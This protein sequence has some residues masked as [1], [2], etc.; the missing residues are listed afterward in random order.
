MLA[1]IWIDKD[2]KPL[3]QENLDDPETTEW[4]NTATL[5]NLPYLAPADGPRRIRSDFPECPT[6]DLRDDVLACQA[7]VE[8]HG[9]EMLVLDQTRPDIGLPVV[10]VIVPGMRHFWPRYAPGRLYDAPVQLGWLPEPL[11]EEDLNP[12]SIFV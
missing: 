6:D 10:K 8:Q 9:M 2:G 4:L 12:T 11:R 1:W 3:V 5:Q 7:L